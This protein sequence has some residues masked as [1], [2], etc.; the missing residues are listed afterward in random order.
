M[1]FYTTLRQRYQY[2]FGSVQTLSLSLLKHTHTNT[3]IFHWSGI[4]SLKENPNFLYLYTLL[5]PT[6]TH[7]HTCTHQCRQTPPW[8]Q[9]PLTRGFILLN[10]NLHNS[11]S[12]AA[13]LPN[14]YHQ[15]TKDQPLHPPSNPSPFPPLTILVAKT[16]YTGRTTLGLSARNQQPIRCSKW[17]CEIGGRICSIIP[18][19]NENCV[20]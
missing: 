18:L 12:S 5:P 20:F 16:Q 10:P 4:S 1:V 3:L 6:T 13:T 8:A 7:A 19:S 17:C 14:I 9:W 15:P 2:I 11:T